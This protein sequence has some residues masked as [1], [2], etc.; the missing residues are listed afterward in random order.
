[1][2][3][4]IQDLRDHLF[5]QLE[6]L[7]DEELTPEQMQTEIQRAN[8]VSGIAQQI[9]MSAKVEVDFIKATGREESK[10]KFLDGGNTENFV[11]G[12]TIERPK[13]EYSN[14]GNYNLTKE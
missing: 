9:V 14:N 6:R 4:K 10:T 7:N 8:A 2:K 5:A 12:K 3:N 1:M 11:E 13:A